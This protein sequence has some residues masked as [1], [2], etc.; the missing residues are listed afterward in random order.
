MSEK[1]NIIQ[2]AQTLFDNENY[3]ESADLVLPLLNDNDV[4]K[5]AT[6]LFTKIAL[7]S[8]E[9]PWDKNNIDLFYKSISASCKFVQ[10]IDE[11]IDLEYETISAFKKWEKISYINILANLESN[12]DKTKLDKFL[13]IEFSYAMM[14]AQI[15]LL[16]GNDQHITDLLNKLGINRKDIESKTDYPISITQDE[17][18]TLILSTAYKIFGKTKEFLEDNNHGNPEYLENVA[19]KAIFEFV[20]AEIMIDTII[21]QKEQQREILL[22]ALFKKAEIIEYS[23]GAC[24]YPNGQQLLMYRGTSRQEKT[25]DLQE[26]YIKINKLDS[27]FEVPELTTP[28]SDNNSGCYI[29]TSVYGSY[30]CHEVWTLRRYRDDILSKNVIGKFFIYCYYKIS[31]KLVKYFGKTNWFRNIWI[32]ILNKTVKKLNNKG[33]KGTPYRDKK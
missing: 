28:P 25:N 33:I 3:T 1:T 12:I 24:L 21:N 26:I 31:P 18:N 23:L 16:I 4:G 14:L 2:K 27:T 20:Y 13:G 15:V 5:E 22:E 30:D 7:F 6:L 9:T 11:Y 29:A 19:K 8:A 10:S 32:F 17:K